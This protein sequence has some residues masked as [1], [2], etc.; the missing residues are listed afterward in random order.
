MIK[1][2]QVQV[3]TEIDGQTVD[4]FCE[5]IVMIWVVV[6]ESVYDAE[7]DGEVTVLRAAEEVLEMDCIGTYD[8]LTNADKAL[9][10]SLTPESKKRIACHAI[11]SWSRKPEIEESIDV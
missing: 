10:F 4:R 3:N 5:A 8:K 6:G 11:R 2:M 9:W 1:P 7:I